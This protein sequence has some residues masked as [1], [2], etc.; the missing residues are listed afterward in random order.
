MAFAKTLA[1]IAGVSLSNY[2]RAFFQEDEERYFNIMH[3]A[4]L[5]WIIKKQKQ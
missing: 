1:K 2:K 4:H 5:I 3:F